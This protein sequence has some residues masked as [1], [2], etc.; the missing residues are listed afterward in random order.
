MTRDEWAILIGIIV[1]LA[2]LAIV[3]SRVH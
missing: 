1:F 2:A 3:I